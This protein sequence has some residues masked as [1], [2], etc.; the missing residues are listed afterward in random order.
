MDFDALFAQ[1]IALLQHEQR[2][3][4]RVLKRRFALS[5]DDLADLKDELIYAKKLAV[6]ENR[7]LVWTGGTA[8]MAL[9]TSTL[10]TRHQPCRTPQTTNEN[11]YPT[12]Q[13]TSPQKILTSRSALEG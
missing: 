13:N 12:L 9:P 3:S 4:Y 7:V 10:H 2:I 8:P 11:P 6:D 5:D 1:V